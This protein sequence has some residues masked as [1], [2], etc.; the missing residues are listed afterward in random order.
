MESIEFI[1]NYQSYVDEISQVVNPKYKSVLNDLKLNDPHNL[2]SPDTWFQNE[3]CAK[4]LV[5]N[6]FIRNIDK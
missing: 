6:L 5:W 2:V 1:R 3:N 4:G